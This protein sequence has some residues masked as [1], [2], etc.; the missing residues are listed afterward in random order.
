MFPRFPSFSFQIFLPGVLDTTSSHVEH[1]NLVAQRLS[2][3]ASCFPAAGR[4]GGDIGRVMSC[5]D[6]GFSTAAGATN[7]SED[8]VWLKLRSMVQGAGRATQRS[9]HPPSQVSEMQKTARCADLPKLGLALLDAF[10]PGH[11]RSTT[12][13]FGKIVTN[14]NNLPAFPRSYGYSMTYNGMLPGY[15]NALHRH[16]NVEI[17]VPINTQFDFSW[18]DAEDEIHSVT[19]DKY[20]AI[21]IPAGV[22]HSYTHNAESAAEEGIILTVLPGKPAIQWAPS[23]VGRARENGAQCSDEG[24]MLAPKRTRPGREGAKVDGTNVK[25]AGDVAA[26]GSGGSA[27]TAD[28]VG[29]D[30]VGEADE[31]SDESD[32]AAAAAHQ[33][34]AMRQ[35]SAEAH[36]K[37]P[38][39][40]VSKE[41]GLTYVTRADFAGKESWGAVGSERRLTLGEGG[42]GLE[43]AFLDLSWK[44]LRKFEV[45]EYY[46]DMLSAESHLGGISEGSRRGIVVVI[47]EGRVCGGGESLAA[48]DVVQAPVFISALTD[49]VKLLEIVSELPSEQN[50][51]YNPRVEVDAAGGK[52]PAPASDSACTHQ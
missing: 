31:G 11:Q 5:T 6:C 19:L 15:G 17:F 35:V 34:A 51:L 30:A 25:V 22:V 28:A 41:E 14:P 38:V 21:A 32:G 47:L 44:V 37:V 12:L 4:E 26:G 52:N 3:Y 2:Q 18:T 27:A 48:L 10:I 36:E 49:H 23:V 24:V 29:V 40:P 13:F 50:F 9:A 7:L 45:R 42:P 46:N 33:A 8:I 20:D 39:R 43:T 1:P 16:P